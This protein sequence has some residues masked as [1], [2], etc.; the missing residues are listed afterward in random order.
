MAEP[1]D[2][3]PFQLQVGYDQE[4]LLGARWWHEGMRMTFAPAP[5]STGTASLDESR[6]R[7]LRVLAITGGGLVLFGAMAV[8]C[9]SDSSSSSGRS[10]ASGVV[11][12]DS[13]ALQ[14]A[15]GLAWQA[16]DVPFAWGNDVIATTDD[17]KPFDPAWL[18]ALAGEL[19]PSDP[20]WLPFY[21]PTLFQAPTANGSA[22]LVA[23]FR[24]VRSTAMQR[25][26]ARGQAVRE[27]LEH[28][29]QAERWLLV[30]D[31]PG[32]ES[33]AFAAALRPAVNVVFAFDNWPHPRGVVPAHL[34]L[35]AAVHY[36][37]RLLATDA[38]GAAMGPLPTALVLDR[39]RLDDYR[40]EPDRFDNR[41]RAKTPPAAE[42]R[43][44]GV[45]RVLYVV[46]ER[47]APQEL[48]DLNARFVEYREANIDVR[49]LGL[50]DLQSAA[51]PN[52]P[53]TR[54]APYYWHGSPGTHWWFWNHYGWPS[55][56]APVTPERPPTNA[57]GSDYR[58]QVRQVGIS[59]FGR[60]FETRPG[61][62]SSSGSSSSGGS[63]GRSSG[64]YGG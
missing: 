55:R 9:S 52:T 59:R 41:Y 21:V 46:P 26:F 37:A 3:P 62:S 58:P 54:P 32:P 11:E 57:F 23:G 31:L 47:A 36:R 44:L 12:H 35:G 56:P 39:D 48:D 17:G 18:P 29:E 30:V 5:R 2:K 7:A 20:R 8:R 28:A 34:T 22:A 40:N 38:A 4:E 50:V 19:G 60:T 49:L 6:R 42:L 51:P 14:R 16:A 25:A 33:V 13:L 61:S 43:K 1:A 45:D 27:L 24:M 64:G 15:N 63:W 53:G 10:S